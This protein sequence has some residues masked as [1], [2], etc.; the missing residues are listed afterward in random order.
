MAVNTALMALMKKGIF[1]TEPYRV[2]FAGKVDAV[3]FDKTGTLTSDRLLPECV[4]NAT[5][6]SDQKQQPVADASAEAA[7]VLA[8]CHSLVAIAGGPLAGDPIELAALEGLGW[9]YEPKGQVATPGT[10]ARH[11]GTIAA[12][13]ARVAGAPPPGAPAS[14]PPPPPLTETQKAAAA[15]EL[16]AAKEALAAAEA[17][18]SACAVRSVRILGRHHF[19]SA[20]QRMSTVADVEGANGGGVAR[21]CLVKGS[22]EALKPLLAQVPEWYEASYR[23]LAEKGMRVLALASKVVDA[24]DAA[25]APSR[26]RE[27]VESGLT[28]RGFIAFACKTRSD[29]RTV[30]TALRESAHAVVMITGDAPLTA[31]HVA[32]EVNICTQTA[33][34][35]LLL[36]TEGAAAG[37]GACWA[38]AVTS[39]GGGGDAAALPK[40]DAAGV[41]A[42]GQTRDLLVTEAALEAAAEATGGADSPIWSQ[43][44]GFLVFARMSPQGKAKVIRNLQQRSGAKVFMCGDGGNDVGALKQADVGLALLSGYGN[45]N[46]NADAPETVKGAGG[47]PTAGDAEKA[48]NAQAMLLQR[49]AAESARLQ[50]EALA[51]K[52]KELQ[53]QQQIWLRE[54]IEEKQARGEE[55]GVMDHMRAL[56]ESTKRFHAELMAERRRLQATGRHCHCHHPPPPLPPPPPLTT[57]SSAAGD[58]WERLR[59]EGCGGRRPAAAAEASELPMVRPGDASVAAPFTSRSPSV[60]N[61]VDLI[62]QGRCTLLSALQQ[63]QIMMLE[64]IISA[65]VFSALSLGGARSSERQMMATSWLLMTASIAFSYATPIEKMHPQRPLR[66]LFHPAV[67]LSMFGQAAIHLFAMQVPTLPPWLPPSRPPAPPPA[68]FSPL[69]G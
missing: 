3:L 4:V 14:A 35:A 22:P 41:M 55:V 2:P 33:Q 16:K 50:K 1:C 46:T 69:R 18:K 67:L 58:P 13:E 45:T 60:R 25:D 30:V 42:L 68:P 28:F 62:R 56:K 66:S 10:T 65:Y 29:S 31:H 5:A 63:Q 26:P 51:K 36:T 44:G 59:Q 15:A 64:S 39:A 47:D 54:M 34:P 11:K 7:T 24:A 12:L 43:L 9:E 40:F 53:A 61:I 20:L 48:L 6:S 27:W 19:A 49:K 23:G 38:L 21:H 37:A 52:Q 57:S 17:K 32:R 8:G